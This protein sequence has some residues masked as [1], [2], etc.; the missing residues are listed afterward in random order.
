M[1]SSKPNSD[2]VTVSGFK[3]GFSFTVGDSN[4][5]KPKYPALGTAND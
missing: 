2:E 3:P 5:V 1:L 4:V